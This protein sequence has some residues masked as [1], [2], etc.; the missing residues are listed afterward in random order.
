M[1]YL[2]SLNDIFYDC[3]NDTIEMLVLAF[4]RNGGKNLE[5]NVLECRTKRGLEPK[6]ISRHSECCLI[7]QNLV[8][9]KRLCCTYCYT[10]ASK[11]QM[12]KGTLGVFSESKKARNQTRTQKKFSN[13]CKRD[14]QDVVWRKISQETDS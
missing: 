1:L 3:S 13:L 14:G 2:A 5:F 9:N 4:K 8:F 11:R 6:Q 12:D 7:Q 10:K